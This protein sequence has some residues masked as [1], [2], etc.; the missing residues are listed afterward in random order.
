MILRKTI[1]VE[2]RCF[3]PEKNHAFNPRECQTGY[4][5]R[6]GAGGCR[7]KHWGFGIPDTWCGI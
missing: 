1:S 4:K 3:L 6:V 5:E 7:F 2:I